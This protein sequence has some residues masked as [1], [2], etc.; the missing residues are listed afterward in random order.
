M[1]IIELD[2]NVVRRHDSFLVSVKLLINA[3]EAALPPPEPRLPARVS[4]ERSKRA[5]MILLQKLLELESPR[6]ETQSCPYPS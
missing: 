6:S 3:I 4:A 1:S 5:S 2:Q